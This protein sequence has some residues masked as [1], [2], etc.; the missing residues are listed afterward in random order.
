MCAARGTVLIIDD[1]ASV[2]QTFC[3]MLQL[4]G[5]DVLTTL[6]GETG[7]HEIAMSRPDAVL[8]DLRMPF[9]DGLMFMRRLR[10]QERERHTPVAII[11]GDYSIDETVSR[12]LRE[13]DAVIHF[14]PLWLED[15]VAIIERLL[16]TIR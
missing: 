10:A 15:L 3:K 8:L 16:R 5:Y 1:D 13:L 14:K 4:E 7:L 6:D 2:T 9:T 12:E 11:T